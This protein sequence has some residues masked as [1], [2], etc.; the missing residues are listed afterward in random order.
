MSL[1]LITLLLGQTVTLDRTVAVV[2]DSPVLHSQVVEF[3]MGMGVDAYQDYETLTGMQSYSEALEELIDNRL[4]IQAGMDAGFYPTDDELHELVEQRLD[5]E[6]ELASMDRGR[7]EDAV[8]E[9]YAAQVFLG[10]R[11]QA[12]ISM[13]PMSPETYLRANS[14]LVED[15]VMPRHIAWLYIPVL[16]SGTDHQAAVDEMLQ[17]RARILA[18]ELFEEMAMEY[19]DDPSA[20]NGGYLGSFA[21]GTMTSGF[22]KALLELE[23]GE[24][25]QPVTTIYGVHLIRLESVDEDGWMTASHILRK[26][27]VD[28]VDV[29]IALQRARDVLQQMENDGMDFEDAVAAYSMDISTSADGGDLGTIP[30]KLLMPYLVPMIEDLQPGSVSDP[31]YLENMNAVAIIKLLEDSDSIDWSSFTD[32]ELGSLVQQVVYQ[33]TY[34]TLVDSLRSEIPVVYLLEN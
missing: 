7:L 26:V 28:S 22:E 9:N 17:L 27:P 15:L 4:L 2:E 14:H 34:N 8:A 11:V 32:S 5:E 33:D 6:P 29:E 30:V 25:S 18:G 24:I 20:S 31:V 12:A 3:L 16:P 21:P 1:I 23:P 13:M 19:S 10:R